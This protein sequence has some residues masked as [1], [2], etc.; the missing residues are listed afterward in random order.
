MFI[1]VSGTLEFFLSEAEK[2]NQFFCDPLETFLPDRNHQNF[3][4][5]LRRSADQ[6]GNRSW[7]RR[8]GYEKK[9]DRQ[10]K[11]FPDGVFEGAVCQ[12]EGGAGKFL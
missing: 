9:K 5:I 12:T 6:S 2:M 10:F 3:C 11:I 4:I 7:N 8:R 1:Y